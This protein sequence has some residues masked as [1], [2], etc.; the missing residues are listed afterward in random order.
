MKATTNL[1]KFYCNQ[2]EDKSLIGKKC[3]AT[4]EYLQNAIKQGCKSHADIMSGELVIIQTQ[5][6][7][8]GQ[9]AVRVQNE[10]I[11]NMHPG[12]GDLINSMIIDLDKIE[13]LNE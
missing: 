5:K 12:Y 9:L 6:N 10:K 1:I 2:V 7:Y 8:R 13:L 11:K 4:Q 3:I